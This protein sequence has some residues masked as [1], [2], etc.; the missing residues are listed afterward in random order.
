MKIFNFSTSSIARKNAVVY[1]RKVIEMLLERD[2]GKIVDVKATM[3]DA[4]LKA[5][6]IKNARYAKSF[7]NWG[8]CIIVYPGLSKKQ[9]S[10]VD[11]L[12]RKFRIAIIR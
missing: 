4:E 9:K 10:M 3:S 2:I 12:H 11:N 7:L 1:D 8:D 6:V 5:A